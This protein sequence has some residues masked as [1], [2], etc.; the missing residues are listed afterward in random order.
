MNNGLVFILALLLGIILGAVIILVAGFIKNKNSESKA[1]KM[2]EQAKKEAE[3]QK[4]DSLLELK[5]E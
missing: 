5:E 2:I 1:S 3:K 4:R